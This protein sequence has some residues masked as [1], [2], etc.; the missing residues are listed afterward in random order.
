MYFPID[1]PM[2][3]SY[4]RPVDAEGTP[5]LNFNTEESVTEKIQ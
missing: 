1:I 3:D 2:S 4:N 5:A